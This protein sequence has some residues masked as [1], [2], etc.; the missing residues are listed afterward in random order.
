MVL[1]KRVFALLATAAAVVAY[2]GDKWA[3]DEHLEARE[4]YLDD[5]ELDFAAAALKRRG[6][7]T[8]GL[9]VK[10]F[11]QDAQKELAK[12]DF[13]SLFQAVQKELAKADFKSLYE[14]LQ[15]ELAMSDNKIKS[16]DAYFDSDALEGRD[17]LGIGAAFGKLKDKIEGKLEERDEDPAFDIVRAR[18][19]YVEAL[20]ERDAFMEEDY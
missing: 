20:Y 11:L 6:L 17:F 15:K 18:D 5:V 9:E 14:K 1:L 12:I 13:M 19:A 2:S 7:E 10:T 4:A 3:R 16:R 8:R